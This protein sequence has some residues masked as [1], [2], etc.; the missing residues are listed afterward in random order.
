[1][2]SNKSHC[3]ECRC[4]GIGR[5]PL[6]D[7][8]DHL[9]YNTVSSVNRAFTLESGNGATGRVWFLYWQLCFILTSPSLSP[10][11][12]VHVQCPFMEVRLLVLANYHRCQWLMI[13]EM[14]LATGFNTFF[15]LD[16][17]C[18]WCFVAHWYLNPIHTVRLSYTMVSHYLWIYF[19]GSREEKTGCLWS[20]GHPVWAAGPGFGSIDRS[21]ERVLFLFPLILLAVRSSQHFWIPTVFQTLY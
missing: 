3:P 16:V 6:S 21:R 8:N 19:R 11:T 10:S 2:Y 7:N 20:S 5:M 12:A 13:R 9:F 15:L 18:S 1:M 4:A 14:N 17:T